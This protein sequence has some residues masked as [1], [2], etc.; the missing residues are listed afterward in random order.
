M[1]PFEKVGF[2]PV[3]WNLRNKRVLID[4]AHDRVP[5]WQRGPASFREASYRSALVSA[6]GMA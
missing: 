5:L 6:L 4:R 1:E 3:A 2:D